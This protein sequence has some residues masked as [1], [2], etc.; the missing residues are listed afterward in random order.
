[1]CSAIDFNCPDDSQSFFAHPRACEKFIE[2]NNGI[3][4]EL[5]CI[6]GLQFNPE[7]GFCDFPDNVVCVIEESE[8]EIV[9]SGPVGSC[10]E[11][12][13]EYVTFLTDGGD[14]TIFYKCNWGVPILFNCPAGLYFNPVLNVCDFPEDAGC[15]LA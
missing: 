1:M 3:A 9:G 15:A 10:P 13:E 4:R 6:E 12:N 2:C 14:C 8:E 5:N 7:V 11:I